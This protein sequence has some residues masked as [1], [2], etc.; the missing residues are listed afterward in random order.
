[1]HKFLN[2]M[3]NKSKQSICTYKIVAVGLSRKG[4]VVDITMSKPQRSRNNALGHAEYQL[5]SKYG[6][7]IHKIVIAR[8]N[9]R[10]EMLPISP[11]KN[12]AGFAERLG[13]VIESL[14]E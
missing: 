6:R 4:N 3:R 10:G 1:M 13:I 14:C 9:V 7:K 2:R 8:F 11:C 5:M 12:C